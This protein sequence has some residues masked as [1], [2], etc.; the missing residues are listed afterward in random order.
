MPSGLLGHRYK[1]IHQVRGATA[2]IAVVETISTG[3]MTVQVS[4][5]YYYK[6]HTLLHF[7]SGCPHYYKLHYYYKGVS[8]CSHSMETSSLLPDKKPVH[9]T[10]LGELFR[11]GASVAPPSHD[12]DWPRQLI[13]PL[14]LDSQVVI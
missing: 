9:R 5:D 1:S 11:R 10:N 12:H 6:S 8:G 14:R 3:K 2:G 13:L 4:V 7:I